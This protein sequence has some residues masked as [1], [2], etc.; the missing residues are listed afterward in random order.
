MFI[1]VLQEYLKKHKMSNMVAFVDPAIIGAIG[2]GTVGDRSRALSIRFKNAQPGQI[3]L[4]PYNSA[5][6]WTL[7]AVNPDSQMVYHMDPLKRRIAAEEWIE[8]VDNAIKLYKDKAKKFLKKKIMWE[9]LAGVPL[10]NG[11]KDCGLFVMGYMKEICED[12]ELK[13][14]EKWLRRMQVRLQQV[15]S[16]GFQS[17]RLKKT[18]SAGLDTEMGMQLSLLRNA[19]LYTTKR[20]ELCNKWLFRYEN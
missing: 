3:F 20:Y 17:S 1:N 10:Q 9:N 5:N 4:L 11:S 8:V 19:R 12:K 13:F 14:P 2:C 15:Q 7:T 6:H 18:G 16:S